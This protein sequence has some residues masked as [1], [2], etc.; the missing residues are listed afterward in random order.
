MIGLSEILSEATRG[1][2]QQYFLL[3]IHG[4]PP[5]QRERVYCYELY[6]Q[7]RRRWPEHCHFSLNGEGDKRAHPH[8]QAHANLSPAIPDLLVHVP[9][10]MVGNHAIIEVKPI[11]AR[12]KGIAKDLR[13][14]TTFVSHWGYQR[15]ILLIYGGDGVSCLARTRR[16]ANRIDHIVPIEVW[17]HPHPEAPAVPLGIVGERRAAA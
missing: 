2:E 17:H 11:N 8:L 12:P 14:L 15:A 5:T 7:M 6:H 16:I 13:T 9:G 1:I 10:N 4:A 3:P